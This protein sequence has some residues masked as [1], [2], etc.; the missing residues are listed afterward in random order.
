MR[1]ATE[2]LIA[3]ASVGA[4]AHVAI[5]NL[6]VVLLLS[7]EVQEPGRCVR[8]VFDVNHKLSLTCCHLLKAV[9]SPQ[10]DRDSQV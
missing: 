6:R 8:F 5:D 7:F 1:H 10:A 9:P 3:S 2:E 4:K